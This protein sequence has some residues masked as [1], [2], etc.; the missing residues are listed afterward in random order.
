MAEE[1]MRQKR[2]EVVVYSAGLHALAGASVDRFAVEAARRKGIDIRGHRA[3]QISTWMVEDADL[4]LTMDRAQKRELEVSY[5]KLKHKVWRLGEYGNYDIPDPYQKAMSVFQE[6]LF[7]IS[8]GVEDWT[9]DLLSSNART[10]DLHHFAAA[11]I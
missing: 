3:R 5:P 4:I 2:P 9:N 6:S 8:L 7:L 11:P 10:A 1:L